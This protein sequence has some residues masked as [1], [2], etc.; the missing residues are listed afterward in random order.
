MSLLLMIYKLIILIAS[1]ASNTEPLQCL[2]N[3]T[4]FKLFLNAPSRGFN[5]IKFKG[6][7]LVKYK[8]A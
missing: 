5:S 2:I 8:T 4:L 1:I 7:G 6:G 3:T